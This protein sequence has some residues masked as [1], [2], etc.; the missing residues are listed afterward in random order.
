MT[1]VQHL[2]REQLLA[3]IAKRDEDNARLHRENARLEQL[4]RLMEQKVDGLVRR[5]FGS[6]SEKLDPAQLQ[7]LLLELPGIA[8]GKARASSL[9]EADPP[10][11][12]VE[13]RRTRRER[14]PQDLPVVEEVLEPDEVQAAPEQ[15]RLIGAEVSE[16]LDYEPARFLLRRLIR[17]K[18]VRRQQR[19]EP[20]VLASPGVRVSHDVEPIP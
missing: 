4:L 9:Q 17:R 20:P 10:R 7:L 15:Y 12:A 16:Q 5:L 8:E 19:D 18:Y 6:S 3:E 2:N 1:C 13:P 11:A 14:W